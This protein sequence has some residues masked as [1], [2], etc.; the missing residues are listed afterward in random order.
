MAR[1]LEKWH[2]GGLS[3]SVEATIKER[4]GRVKIGIFETVAI[5]EDTRMQVLSGVLGVLEIWEIALVPVILNNC[6]TWT[7]ISEQSIMELENLQLLF[8]RMVFQVAKSAPKPIFLWD[9]NALS[10][11]CLLYTSPSQRDS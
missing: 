8:F 6:E 3:A 4:S 11:N 7:D 2:K 5:L 10:M 1:R 9:P